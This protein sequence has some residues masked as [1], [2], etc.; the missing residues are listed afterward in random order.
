MQYCSLMMKHL[1]KNKKSTFTW[2]H[3]NIYFFPTIWCMDCKLSLRIILNLKLRSTVQNF[4]LCWN[5]KINLKPI[6]ND[7]NWKTHLGVLK[8]IK[9]SF[10]IHIY[11]SLSVI[12]LL[13][14]YRCIYCIITSYGKLFITT[15]QNETYI[16]WSIKNC[17]WGSSLT[18]AI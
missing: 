7:N 18:Y 9:L 11:I 13:L 12:N 6:I 5:H 4:E 8:R 16:T 2:K 14:Q 1:C 17:L 10:Y 15:S 3:E